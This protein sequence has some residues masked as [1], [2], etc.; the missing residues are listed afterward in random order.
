MSQVAQEITVSP[1][2]LV[3]S[4]VGETQQLTATVQDAGGSIMSPTVLWESTDTNIV[5]VDA[6]GYVTAVSN[7][8]TQVSASVDTL[9][10][11]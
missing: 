3:F 1:T 9:N 4:N 2:E 11:L 7:G 6:M 10:T 8:T 5:T